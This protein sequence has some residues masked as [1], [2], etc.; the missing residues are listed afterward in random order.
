MNRTQCYECLKPFK[1]GRMSVG[2]DPRP[3]RSSISTNVDHVEVVRAVICVNRRLTLREVAGEGGI[4][5]GSC[6]QILLKIFRCVASVQNSCC[7]C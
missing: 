7:V 6:H 2:E 1:V 3:G 4:R 5:I